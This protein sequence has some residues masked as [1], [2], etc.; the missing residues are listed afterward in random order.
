MYNTNNDRITF[1]TKVEEDRFYEGVD[2]ADCYEK[3]VNGVRTVYSTFVKKDASSSDDEEEGSGELHS[4]T[5][6]LHQMTK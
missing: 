3:E 1:K 2:Q 5:A 6:A 4:D